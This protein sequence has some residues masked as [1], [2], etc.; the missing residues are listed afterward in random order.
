[1]SDWRLTIPALLANFVAVPA[2]AIGITS[3]FSLGEAREVGV[4]VVA[5]AA[6]APFVI[7]LTQLAGSDVAASSGLLVLLL[8]VTIG[9]MPLVV[10]SIA[11]D[12]DVSALAIA[13][14]LVLTMLLPIV[15]RSIA[16]KFIP[17]WTERIRP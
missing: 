15:F 12:A 8:V 10:P 17:G 7:T 6:G 3:I 16:T 1:M 13:Q 4:I 9:Y 14:P 11:P 2:L 5:S